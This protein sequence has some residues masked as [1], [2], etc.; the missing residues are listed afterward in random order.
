MQHCLQTAVGR[1]ADNHLH[2]HLVG[3][4]PCTLHTTTP[5]HVK[6]AWRPTHNKLHGQP[7]TRTKHT[8]YDIRR[9]D[10]SRRTRT[11]TENL[12]CVICRS[13]GLRSSV[14]GLSYTVIFAGSVTNNL[15]PYVA[16]CLSNMS[17]CKGCLVSPHF[18]L[19]ALMPKLPSNKGRS[20]CFSVKSRSIQLTGALCYN[21]LS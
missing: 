4:I 5:H 7:H 2:T 20:T 11:S 10:G 8:P 19:I 1:W 3:G 21:V 15:S 12:R 13:F 14:F 9:Y 18:L 16:P 17:C 6:G